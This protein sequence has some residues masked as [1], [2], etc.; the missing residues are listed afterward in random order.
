MRICGLK[1]VFMGL[2]RE[3]QAVLTELR[4]CEC[5]MMIGG[6]GKWRTVLSDGCV[7]VIGLSICVSAVLAII[8]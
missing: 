1:I 5:N 6:E 3:D 8:S 7:T 4:Q 2:S